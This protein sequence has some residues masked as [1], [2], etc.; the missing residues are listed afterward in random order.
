MCSV[1]EETSCLEV[2]LKWV[3][4][5]VLNG[6]YNVSVSLWLFPNLKE[7]KNR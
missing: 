4:K 7:K 6:V 1:Y 5:I 3:R 2:T